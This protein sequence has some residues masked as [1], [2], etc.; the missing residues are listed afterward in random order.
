MVFIALIGLRLGGQ[1]LMIHISQSVMS[2]HFEKDR[3]KALSLT[4]LGYSLGEIIFPL[5]IALILTLTDWRFALFASTAMLLLILL[6]VLSLLKLEE[7]DVE[8]LSDQPSKG[9]E[10]HYFIEILREKS[11]WYIALPSFMVPFM[12]TGLFFYQYVLAEARGWPLEWYALCFAGYAGMRMLFSFYGGILND[13]FTARELFPYLLIPLIAGLFS[14]AWVPGDYAALLFLLL[15]GVTI[16]MS[17]VV[18]IALIA[19]IYGTQK[20]GQVKSLFTV[21][22]VIFSAFGPMVVG[23]LLDAGTTFSQ[24][25][26]GSGLVLTLIMI[27]TFITAGDTWFARRFSWN[28]QYQ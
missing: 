14:L 16:G 20:I 3:G 11:F 1:S 18:K 24:I 6:P 7:Y 25:A 17:S 8:Q 19:E 22:M 13:R 10:W 23:F 15:T 12:T 4:S 28:T 9:P 26:W 5:A 2:R 21:G 27:N